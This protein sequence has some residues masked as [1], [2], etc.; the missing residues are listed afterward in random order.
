MAI[1]YYI[2]SLPV[3]ECNGTDI[4]NFPFVMIKDFVPVASMVLFD[5]VKVK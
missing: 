4:F 1:S 2:L 5:G 3:L